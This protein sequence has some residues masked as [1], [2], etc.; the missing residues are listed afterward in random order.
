MRA[1]ISIATQA[2]EGREVGILH[3]NLGLVLWGFEGP[4]AG[5][6]GD[7][8]GSCSRRLAGS[9]RSPTSLAA[10]RCRCS[11]T[12]AST[13]RLS[14]AR[15]A[16]RRA[17]RRAETHSCRPRSPRRPGSYTHNP[18][19]SR[20]IEW[21][22]DMRWNHHPPS[23]PPPISRHSPSRRRRSHEALGHHKAADGLLAELD[24]NPGVRDFPYYVYRLPM[25][26]RIALIEDGP[27]LATRLTDGV[28]PRTP[29]PPPLSSPREP[30][31]PR[32]RAT[33]RSPR[34]GT[35]RLSNAGGTSASSPSSAM[36]CSA[37]AAP[38]QPSDQTAGQG[39]R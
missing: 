31:S 8:A 27:E 4:L 14:R 25:I 26:V 35:P 2:G 34:T 30:R 10:Q 5:P 29:M 21:T 1:A 32:P 17:Q 7:G 37:G 16:S 6:R 33:F 38:S 12:A 28:Q 20:Q 23:R 9:T 11:S 24:A 36:R 13:I 15:S 3:N 39:R 18:R 22:L 19:A